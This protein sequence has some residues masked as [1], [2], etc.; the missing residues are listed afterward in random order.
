MCPFGLCFSLATCPVVGLL[1]AVIVLFI[2]FWVTC[3]PLSIVAA[4][5]FI[6]INNAR[7]FSFLHPLQ[8]LLCVD[9]F[10]V[11]LSIIS[12]TS[13]SS[14]CLLSVS[15]VAQSCPTLCDPMD[16]SMPSLPVHHQLPE[17]TQTHVHPVSDAMQLFYPLLSP[18]LPAFNL[19]QHQGLFKWVSSSHQVAKVSLVF[20]L[21]HQS[22]Q[23]IFRTDFL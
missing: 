23:W 1:G 7:G 12:F 14:V 6:L 9:V 10:I 2:V 15:S 5:V 21:Q 8:H 22:F 11:V 13:W 19:S 18:S 16:C 17:F 20:Q 3:I 4:P